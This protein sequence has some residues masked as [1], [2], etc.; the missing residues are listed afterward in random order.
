MRR[1]LVGA[2]DF[3]AF[4]GQGEQAQGRSWRF[5]KEGDFVCM[6]KRKKK[7]MKCEEGFLVLMCGE[8]L[9]EK[10]CARIKHGRKLCCSKYL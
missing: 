6:W 8:V 4:I 9:M 2:R 10:V 1:P 5:T 7:R 3:K